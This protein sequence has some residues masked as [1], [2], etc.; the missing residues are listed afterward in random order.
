MVAI[1]LSRFDGDIGN[2]IGKVGTAMRRAGYAE[3]AAE[4]SLKAWRTCK[5]TREAIE[6]ARKYGVIVE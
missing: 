6:L 3:S 4:F 5:D 1:N 2:F